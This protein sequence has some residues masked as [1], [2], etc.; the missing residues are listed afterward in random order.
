MQITHVISL[1]SGIAL[2]LFGMTLMGDGLKKVAGNRLELI[3]YRLSDT[4]L[5]GMLLGTGVTAV[6]QSSCATSVMVVG[7]VNAGMM[8]LKQSVSVILGAILG[9]SVTGW[10]ICLGY[11]EDAGG[12]KSLL[13]TATLTGVIAV[14]GIILRMFVKKQEKKIVG[15]ILMGFAVLMFGMSVM[16]AA[17]SPLG[18]DAHFVGLLTTLSHPLLGILAGTVFTALLQS[19]SAAVGIIQA[20]AVTGVME[21]R[22]ALPLLMGIA[23]GAAAPVLLSAIGAGTDGKRASLIYPIAGVLGVTGVGAVFYTLHAVLKFDFLSLTVSP[24][25]VAAI[26]SFLRIAMVVLLMPFYKALAL[27][28]E[29]LVKAKA[30]ENALPTLRLE[31]RFL[32]HPALAIEQSRMAVNEMANLT[33][34]SIGKAIRLVETYSETE[35]EAVKQ[36]ENT[37]DA[38]EDQLGAYL[39]QMTGKVLSAEQNAAVFKDLHA[40]TDLERISDHALNIAESAKE[41]HEKK[42]SFSSDAAKELHVMFAAV[43]EVI[44]LA[45]RAFETDD[46]A[47]AKQVEPLEECIDV[48][49]DTMKQ[50]HVERLQSGTC[51]I[52]QG[53][54][55]NDLVTN[56]E[57][58]ADHCSNLAVALIESHDRR[59]AAHD[60]SHGVKNDE[61]FRAAYEM[62]ARRYEI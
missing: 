33:K 55:F 12:L 40:L 31:Q 7:F 35:F 43:T 34:K 15:D 46:P 48:L 28:V 51:T 3:L 17:V 39:T 41:L 42:I 11:I 52:V 61:E 58:V 22:Q 8:K 47:M 36:M 45:V 16:S 62:Y 60:Y 24:F 10:V 25:S 4:P 29:K 9:T 18:E 30:P 54:V 38:Y 13:S 21:V 53:F 49:C 6:I 59:V 1:V 50:R 32:Q 26:N 57:R 20:L 19:A 44:H 23:V 14:V 27:L 37:V 2:F 56:F 5:K